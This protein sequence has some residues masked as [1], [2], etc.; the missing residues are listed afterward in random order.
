[1]RIPYNPLALDS[2]LSDGGGV[3]GGDVENDDFAA[4]LSLV[5]ESDGA[6]TAD[7]VSGTGIPKSHPPRRVCNTLA[8]VINRVLPTSIFIGTSPFATLYGY[9]DSSHAANP[10]KKFRLVAS[11]FTKTCETL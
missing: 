4:I 9:G 3:S 10:S 7:I 8:R 5:S 2:P 6:T 11:L 1:M